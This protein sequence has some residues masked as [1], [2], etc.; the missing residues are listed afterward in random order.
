MAHPKSQTP[1]SQSPNLLIGGRGSSV[2]S[3]LITRS[4]E[5]GSGES[6]LAWESSTILHSYVLHHYSVLY[7]CSEAECSTLGMPPSGLVSWCLP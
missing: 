1:K 4:S 3:Q 6:D 7:G 2:S 5:T